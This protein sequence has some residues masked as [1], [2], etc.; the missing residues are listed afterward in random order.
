MCICNFSGKSSQPEKKPPSNDSQTGS[1]IHS[2]TKS[3]ARRKALEYNGLPPNAK[4]DGFEE[5]PDR[6]P[7]IKKNLLKDAARGNPRWHEPTM[8]QVEIYYHPD[9]YLVYL[10]PDT[11]RDYDERRPKESNDKSGAQKA[12]FNV[13]YEKDSGIEETD[14][15]HTFDEDDEPHPQ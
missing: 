10:R 9:G 3:D 2:K 7:D 14:Q 15:H 5:I 4:P 13:Y 6:N 1:T 8:L 12:H 11:K